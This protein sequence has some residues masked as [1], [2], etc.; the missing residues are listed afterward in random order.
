MNKIDLENYGLDQRV[1]Q[2]ASMYQGLFVA[3]RR[4]NIATYIR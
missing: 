1:K 3:R 4:N 2:E